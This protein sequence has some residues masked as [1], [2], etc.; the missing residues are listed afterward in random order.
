MRKRKKE[1]GGGGKEKLKKEEEKKED[2]KEKRER[3]KRE[4]PWPTSSV[5]YSIVLECQGCVFIPARDI[6]EPTNG[7]GW[8][9]LVD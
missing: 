9:G 4:R 8:C 2:K 6:H 5:C 3:K 7:T 1:G